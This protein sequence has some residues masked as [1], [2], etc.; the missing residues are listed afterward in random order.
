MV[1]G[2]LHEGAIGPTIHCHDL[3][4]RHCVGFDRHVLSPSW[5]AVEDNPVEVHLAEK[6]VTPDLKV[7]TLEVWVL[8]TSRAALIWLFITSIA[9]MPVEALST[10]ICTALSRLRGPSKS[11]SEAMR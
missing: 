1:D 10:A 4:G 8:V 6:T 9:P 5:C 7:S 2:G 3:D 11:G